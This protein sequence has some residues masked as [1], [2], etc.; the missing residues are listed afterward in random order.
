MRLEGKLDLRVG[1]EEAVELGPDVV[2]E[3]SLP[4]QHPETDLPLGL[5]GAAAAVC[6][7]HL[8]GGLERAQIIEERRPFRR[9]R[10]PLAGTARE[11]R[12]PELFFQRLH[13]VADRCL[14]NAE[15][16]GAAA[17]AARGAEAGEDFQLAQG[18]RQVGHYRFQPFS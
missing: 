8:A 13:L 6:G 16:F 18:E 17:E 11:Q 1:G 15:A 5:L 10:R 4:D 2:V 12:Q 3:Q 7:E 9:E 14:R